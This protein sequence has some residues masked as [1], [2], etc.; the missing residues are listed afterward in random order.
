MATFNITVPCG[1]QPT[2]TINIYGRNQRN[3]T[4][5]LFILYG[6]SP[7]ASF[8]NVNSTTCTLLATTTATN[9]TTFYFGAD[10]GSSGVYFDYS[11][12]TCPITPAANYCGCSG[13]SIL[14]SA[15]INIYITILVNIAGDPT[16]CPPV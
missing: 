4:S 2:R 12:S 3:P 5:N 10:N 6:S 11:L 9:N 15:N 14:L 16:L 13:A 1:T 7:C 8:V